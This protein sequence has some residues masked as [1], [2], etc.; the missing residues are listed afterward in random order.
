M[1]EQEPQ[2]I[3]GFLK[4]HFDDSWKWIMQLHKE[5][6]EVKAENLKLKLQLESKDAEGS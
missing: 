5:L 1:F 3:I 2:V 6:E 4:Q